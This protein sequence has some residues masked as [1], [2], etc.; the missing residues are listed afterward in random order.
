MIQICYFVHEVNRTLLIIGVAAFAGCAR[1]EPFFG[2][3]G[4]TPGGGSGATANDAGVAAI[5]DTGPGRDAGSPSGVAA[6]PSSLTFVVRRPG[7]MFESALLVEA[8]GRVTLTDIRLAGDD[9]SASFGLTNLTSRLPLTLEAGELLRLMVS[10]NA[11]GC[12]GGSE[13]VLI[14]ASPGGTISVPVRALLAPQSILEPPTRVRFGGTSGPNSPR[15]AELNIVNGGCGSLE[16]NM[17]T[18]KGPSGMIEHPS[19]DDFMI[20]GCNGN[21]CSAQISLCSPFTEGCR[22]PMIPVTLFYANNDD[23]RVDLA[24][25]HL[26]TNDPEDSEQIVLMSAE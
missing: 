24:E 4:R 9:A 6:Q 23:S 8:S 11:V 5:R 20:D 26:S 13:R 3:R 2:A 16:V 22:R 14:E 10:F 25:L 7:D 12:S 18:I 17:F 1:G 19:V 21:P 15:F